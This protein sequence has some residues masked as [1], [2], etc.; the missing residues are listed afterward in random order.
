MSRALGTSS[1]RG[2][3][4]RQVR[5]AIILCWSLCALRASSTQAAEPNPIYIR[6]GAASPDTP[7]PLRNEWKTGICLGI[8]GSQAA[9]K[10]VGFQCDLNYA[11]FPFDTNRT[12]EY[13]GAPLDVAQGSQSVLTLMGGF[14]FSFLPETGAIVPYAFAEAGILRLSGA[15]YQYSGSTF[16]SDAEVTAG[17]AFGGGLLV[18]INSRIGCFLEASSVNGPTDGAGTGDG[19]TAIVPLCLGVRYW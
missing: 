4:E 7:A 15:E 17:L 2:E 6:V 14:R 8:G 12:A 1:I 18:R 16:R 10:L 9:N 19:S 13:P 5:W 3:R 11:R